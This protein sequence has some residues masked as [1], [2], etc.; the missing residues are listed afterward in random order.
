MRSKKDH[1]S[2]LH[3]SNLSLLSNKAHITEVYVNSHF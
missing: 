2:L 3:I 1:P